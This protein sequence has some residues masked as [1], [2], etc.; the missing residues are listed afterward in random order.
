MLHLDKM[1]CGYGN[2]TVVEDLSFNIARGEIFALIGANGAGK[3]STIMSIAGHVQVKSGKILFKERDITSVPVTKRVS[4]GIAIVPEGR[5]LFTDM[6]VS[7]NLA[8]GCYSLPKSR[9]SRNRDKVLELFPRLKERINQQA[10]SLS[11]GEQQM[12]SIGRA[13]MAEPELLII[14]ELSLGLM[15]KVIDL[16]YQAITALREQGVTILLVEQNTTRA[17]EVAERICVLESGRDVW[18]GTA[19]KACDDPELI[20]AYLGLNQE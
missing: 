8:M 19:A 11:G 1:S 14:D 18:Q 7:E 9:L 12:L 13:L 20:K 2:L 16:C 3:S 10:S 5:R 6:S 15:P 4:L 17:L